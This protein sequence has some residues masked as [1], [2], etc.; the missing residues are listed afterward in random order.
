[1]TQ[2]NTKTQEDNKVTIMKAIRSIVRKNRLKQREVAKLLGVK[3]PRVSDLLMLKHERFSIDL[4]LIYFA[5]FGFNITFETVETDRGK[6][7]KI[8][9]L[10]TKPNFPKY[11]D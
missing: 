11:L 3:Q 2:L 9:I 1:M 10:K 6:P 4:L 7:V 5:Q 8:N